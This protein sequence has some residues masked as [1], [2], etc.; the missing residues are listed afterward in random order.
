MALSAAPNATV[1]MHVHYQ[2]CDKRDQLAGVMYGLDIFVFYLW[3]GKLQIVWA[4][5]LRN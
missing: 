4:L 3:I 5:F 1:S 2:Y